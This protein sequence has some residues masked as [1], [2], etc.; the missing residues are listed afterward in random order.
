MAEKAFSN[1][2][3][4]HADW[5]AGCIAGVYAP[6]LHRHTVQLHIKLQWHALLSFGRVALCGH[7]LP[8][9]QL[10][11]EAVGRGSLPKYSG[12]V[13]VSLLHLH[14]GSHLKPDE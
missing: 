8:E 11:H 7:L 9:L 13:L 2:V 10:Q 4:M 1:L 6:H 14:C 3:C 12:V 5:P